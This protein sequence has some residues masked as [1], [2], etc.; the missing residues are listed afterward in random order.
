MV[1][2]C[3][4]GAMSSEQSNPPIAE[5][6]P[7]EVASPHGTRSDP[8]YWLRDDARANPA[9]LAHL[10]AENA[11]VNAVLAPVAAL[12]QQLFNELR[13]R[14][15]EDD[16]S[17]PTFD[18]GYWYYA[19]FAAGKQ[20][21]IHVRRAGNSDAPTGEEEVLLDGNQLAIGHAFYKLENYEISPD[22]RLLAWV[23][24]TVG[25]NQF[26]LR[27][28]ELATGAMLP[29]TASNITGGLAWSAD[30]ATV[31]YVGRDEVTLR[32]DRVFRLP[33]GGEPALVHLEKDGQFYVGIGA[34]KSR[35]YVLIGIRSTTTAEILLID[36]EQPEVP[37]RVFAVRERDHLYSLD[38]LDE[39]F[40]ILTNDRG[41]NFRVAEVR[42]GE[43]GDR[44]NWRDVIAHRDDTLIES[45]EIFDGFVAASVRTGGLRKVRVLPGGRD[46]EAFV[47]E[48]EDPAYAMSVIDTPDPATPRVRYAYDSLTRP[49]SVFELDVATGVRTLKKQQPVP[50]YDPSRYA[51]AYLHATSADGTA[52]PVS[53][54]YRRD[55]PLDG[56][57]PLLIYGYGSY[58]FS[59]E[60]SF[61]A[62]RV[63]LLDRGWVY[64]IAHIRGGQEL[65]RA[66]YEAGKLGAK[67]NTFT[68]FVAVTEHLLAQ[69]YGAHGKV[70][71][72]GGS[73][74]GLLVGAVANLRPD[75]Y[76]GIASFVPFV[77]VVTTMLDESIPLTT[78]EYDEWGNPTADPAAYAYMLSYSPYDN[79]TAQ[80]Y[81]AIYVHTGLWDSQVQYFEPAKWVARLRATKRDANPVL[82]DTNMSAGHGGA[83]GR[84]DALREVARAYA[85]LL[86]TL[87]TPDPRL[88]TPANGS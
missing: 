20:Y 48:A 71:A 14:I 5:Q 60:P 18:R 72:M 69:G 78:N 8:Y 32:S 52:V 87:A 73:A 44:A 27:V 86:Q 22:G 17:V 31:F 54:V 1:K 51:S 49:S 53:V 28:R 13:A 9:V 30:S 47:V 45:V 43:E 39:H 19:R 62:A 26:V 63:S 61:G 74:G 33:L 65:G 70:F 80:A 11:Y 12:E 67:H 50:T 34:T 15:Q 35:R 24:D 4:P 76:R 3:Y 68:D 21:P 29:D 6:R 36:A 64:A 7:H 42:D 83:S 16:S 85:F 56:T 75:L 2:Q 59:T 41:K 37:P 79:I 40:I 82:L 66:W 25:R 84:F 23:E 58:G 10:V 88:S 81:P 38:H 57:A 46:A 77:D 55:T